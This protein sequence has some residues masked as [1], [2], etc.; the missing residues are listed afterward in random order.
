MVSDGFQKGFG[1]VQEKHSTKA[2]LYVFSDACDLRCVVLI[3]LL[4]Q[5]WH[6]TTSFSQCHIGAIN[7][8]K[9]VL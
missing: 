6:I 3:K 1:N 9:H 7:V 8:S 5:L 4:E 2:R